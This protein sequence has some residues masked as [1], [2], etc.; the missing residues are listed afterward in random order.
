M[1]QEVKE[2]AWTI[3][4]GITGLELYPDDFSILDAINDYGFE[5]ICSI[6][7]V[8]GWAARYTLPG[9]LDCTDWVGVSP[10]AEDALN[11][12]EEVYGET[13]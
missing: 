9:C 13:V 10:S 4:D 8:Y 3:I 6:E 11:A 1:E 2:S 5:G 12:A 7:V